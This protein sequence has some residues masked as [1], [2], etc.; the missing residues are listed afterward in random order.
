[1]TRSEEGMFTCG[2]SAVVLVLRLRLTLWLYIQ[3]AQWGVFPAEGSS[4]SSV[5]SLELLNDGREF[6]IQGWSAS[7][8]PGG[9]AWSASAGVLLL[10]V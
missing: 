1:M 9:R 3:D 10:L 6:G 7:F 5:A 4:S 2:I 8:G